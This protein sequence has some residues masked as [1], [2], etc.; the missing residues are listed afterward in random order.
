MSV[1]VSLATAAGEASRTADSSKIPS[2]ILVVEDEPE[3][4]APLCHTL[5]RAGYIVIEAEDG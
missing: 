3:I 2:A 4:L 5:R 1:A